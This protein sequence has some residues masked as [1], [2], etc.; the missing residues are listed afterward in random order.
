MR[1]V[2]AVRAQGER[3]G[4]AIAVL[5]ALERSPTAVPPNTT[6]DEDDNGVHQGCQA[7]QI[8]GNFEHGTA[9]AQEVRIC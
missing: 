2:K 9:A 3:A 1:V 6:A 8:S 5:D 7:A 4:E